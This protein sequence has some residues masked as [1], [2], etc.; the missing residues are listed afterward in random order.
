MGKKSK[1]KPSRNRS[2][3]QG[4]TGLQMV[5][6]KSGVKEWLFKVRE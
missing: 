4:N 2:M 5:L 3:I 6:E 1:L